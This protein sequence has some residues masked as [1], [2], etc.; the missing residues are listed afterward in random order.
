[1][2]MDVYFEKKSDPH[3]GFDRY[4]QSANAKRFGSSKFSSGLNGSH[5]IRSRAVAFELIGKKSDVP[6]LQ[7]DLI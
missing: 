4:K 7:M 1:M 2:K 3:S 6:L 5:A